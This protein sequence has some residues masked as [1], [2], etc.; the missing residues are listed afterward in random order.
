MELRAPFAG[1]DAVL[2][3]LMSIKA[4]ESGRRNSMPP[5]L[6]GADGGS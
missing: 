3:R 5:L 4:F 6:V 1:A 2:P